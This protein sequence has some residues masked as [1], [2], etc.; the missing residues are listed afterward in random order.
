MGTSTILVPYNFTAIDQ[1]T[2]EFITKTFGPRKETKI[3]LFHIYIP[4][5]K[6]ETASST[7]MGRLS[8]S[9]HY[10]AGDLKEKEATLR[11]ARKIILEKGF[12]EQQVDYIFRP[13]SKPVAE[14]I[15]ETAAGRYDVI[16]L[17]YRPYRITRTFVQSV[18]NKVIAALRDITVCIVT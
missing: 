10:L 12:A 3:T 15:I 2:I 5:P 13:R 6:I 1:K 4:L 9:M 18:H 14:E 11:N 8:S 16:V 17:S 7:V